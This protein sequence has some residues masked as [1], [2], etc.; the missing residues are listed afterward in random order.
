MSRK[1]VGSFRSCRVLNC[2]PPPVAVENYH[3]L[4]EDAFLPFPNVETIETKS[5]ESDLL[6]VYVAAYGTVELRTVRYDILGTDARRAS[7]QEKGI[8][9]LAQYI[10][11]EDESRVKISM[12]LLLR[13]NSH[14]LHV[15]LY[16]PHFLRELGSLVKLRQSSNECGKTTEIHRTMLKSHNFLS[17]HPLSQDCYFNMKSFLVLLIACIIA[18]CVNGAEQNLR[19]LGGLTA[20]KCVGLLERCCGD[21]QG[22]D[23]SYPDCKCPIRKTGGLEKPTWYSLGGSFGGEG[24]I[25]KECS[26]F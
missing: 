22:G 26:K 5:S 1:G 19:K 15:R 10:I 17:R 7:L 9:N 6:A 18:V 12:S 13:G 11:V 16:F 21:P 3:P 24:G 25:C 20:E 8:G 4:P 2:L 23:E 14:R